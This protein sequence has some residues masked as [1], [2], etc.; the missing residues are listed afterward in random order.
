MCSKWAG[1]VFTIGLYDIHI[2]LKHIPLLEITPEKEML[3]MQANNVMVP[4][5]TLVSFQPVVTV[6]HLLT[7]LDRCEHNGFPVV[8]EGGYFVGLVKRDTLMQ[9]LWRGK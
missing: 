8:L 9:V 5:E 4:T 7:T 1:D 3:H 6:R 2:E